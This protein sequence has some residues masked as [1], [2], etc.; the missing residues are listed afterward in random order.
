MLLGADLVIIKTAGKVEKMFSKREICR[1]ELKPCDFW[2]GSCHKRKM[3]ERLESQ[4]KSVGYGK[5]SSLHSWNGGGTCKRSRAA[6]IVTRR[7][8]KNLCSKGRGGNKG[9]KKRQVPL[10]TGLL[11]KWTT[12]S[13]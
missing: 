11:R 13:G 9:I 12:S 5:C 2:E 8:S 1:G 6:T 7:Q 10:S 3:V 4:L